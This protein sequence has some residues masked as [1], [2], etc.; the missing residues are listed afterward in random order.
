[1]RR[2]TPTHHHHQRSPSF[3]GNASVTRKERFP[4]STSG[5]LVVQLSK[6]PSAEFITEATEEH[7]AQM[8]MQESVFVHLSM[9]EEGILNVPAAKHL[10]DLQMFV[11]LFPYLNGNHRIEEIMYFEKL[12]RSQLLTL[13]DKFCDV[14]I[15]CNYQDPATTFCGSH[16]VR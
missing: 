11:R 12:R 16:R 4:Q 9:E 5:M 14:L 10:D 3:S 7:K 8:S 2:K 6:S 1:M 15:L 13:L